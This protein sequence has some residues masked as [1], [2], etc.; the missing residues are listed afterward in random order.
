MELPKLIKHNIG[1][2]RRTPI[3]EFIVELQEVKKLGATHL[4]FILDTD[5]GQPT[6][7]INAISKNK[8]N[9]KH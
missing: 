8:E 2:D 3:D 7:F 4:D 9:G 6:L 5:W 1:W